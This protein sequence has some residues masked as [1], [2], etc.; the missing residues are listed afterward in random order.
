MAIAWRGHLKDNTASNQPQLTAKNPNPVVHRAK[1]C[2]CPN[3]ALMFAVYLK[4]AVV[5][6][7]SSHT[8]LDLSHEQPV[9]SSAN[10]ILRLRKNPE[11]C[12]RT[13]TLKAVQYTEPNSLSFDQ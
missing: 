2:A 4:S 10:R 5:C 12:A 3:C 8:Y 6:R 13:V 11:H 7:Q 9:Y 1:S